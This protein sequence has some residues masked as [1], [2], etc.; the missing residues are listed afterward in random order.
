[1]G[2]CYRTA[3]SACEHRWHGFVYNAW[4]KGSPCN[5]WVKVGLGPKSRVA[6]ARNFLKPWFFIYMRHGRVDSF[7]FA[8]RFVD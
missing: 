6:T 3:A 1:M 8:L 2:R 7:Y 4:S 5:C